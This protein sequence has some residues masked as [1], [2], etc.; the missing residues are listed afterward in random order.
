MSLGSGLGHPHAAQPWPPARGR[1][2]GPYLDRQSHQ[3]LPL[4]L[5]RHGVVLLRPH[6]LGLQD[7]AS[8]P[9]EGKQ[10]VVHLQ[11]LIWRGKITADE[12]EARKGAPRCWVGDDLYLFPKII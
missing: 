1:R 2:A 4:G 5:G 6:A 7:V 8:P 11:V 3:D 9:I 12:S 10:G